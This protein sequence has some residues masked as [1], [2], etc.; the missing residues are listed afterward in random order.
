M[1]ASPFAKMES[2]F[3]IDGRSTIIQS[4]NFEQASHPSI[5][6]SKCDHI[7]NINFFAG[8]SNCGYDG[9]EKNLLGLLTPLY[10]Q[11]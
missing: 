10:F 5:H 1:D 6:K 8:P 11:R 7:Y 9:Y 2:N 4:Y 3:E